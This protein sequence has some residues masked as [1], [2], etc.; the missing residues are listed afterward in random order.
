[1]AAGR[2][3]VASNIG[4]VGEIL[5]EA[6]AYVF[7]GD[8]EDSMTAAFGRARTAS[9]DERV[10]KR[11]RCLELIRERYNW[12]RRVAFILDRWPAGQPV[13]HHSTATS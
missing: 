8:D 1:M 11:T 2:T 3:I 6:N 12:Y 10:A 7:D 4:S 13:K 5:N 9:E